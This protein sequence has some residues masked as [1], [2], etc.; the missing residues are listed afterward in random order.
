[1]P[2]RYK[3]PRHLLTSHFWSI[4]QR[5]EFQEL[6][7]R[8]RTSHNR[9]IFRFLQAKLDQTEDSGYYQTW[10]YILGLLGSGTH[11][12]AEEILS[13]RQIF[14]DDPYDV[15]HLTSSHLS[16][17]CK[18]HGIHSLY[19]KRI[20]LTEHA[21]WMYNMDLAIKKEGGV[22]NLH[23]DALRHSCY[24]RGLNPAN[25]PNEELVEWLR[26]WIKVSMQIRTE[27]PSLYLHLP[28]LLSYNHPNNWRLTHK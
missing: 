20:R 7:L 24:L 12:S 27:I 4:Q 14:S 6:Y 25:L 21:Y 9:K 2:R 23:S 16:H 5:S 19:L 11:P 1:L 13:V 3:F 17:L 28:I 10:N 26:E 22:H 8:D 18:L 15:D